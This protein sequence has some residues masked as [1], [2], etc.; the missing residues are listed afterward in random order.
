MKKNIRGIKE[1]GTKKLLEII[2]MT[3]GKSREQC[4]H[5]SIVPSHKYMFVTKE[6]VQGGNKE[7]YTSTKNNLPL[8]PEAPIATFIP[9]LKRFPRTIVSWISSSKHAKKHS[10]HKAS[11]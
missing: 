3:S 6:E 10:L 4:V 11:P 7:M 8:P 9:G 5:S 1:K 2:Q